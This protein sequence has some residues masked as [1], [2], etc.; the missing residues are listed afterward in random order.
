MDDF[1]NIRN[2][3]RCNGE[4]G[5]RI[6]SWFTT[7]TICIECST[8]EDELKKKLR[9]KGFDPSAYEGCGYLPKI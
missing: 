5:A 7:E 4:L 1:F 8:K 2:C 9:D 3:Q 6:M